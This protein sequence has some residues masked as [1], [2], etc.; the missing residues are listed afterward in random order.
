MQSGQI[1]QRFL[2]S[3]RRAATL[4]VPTSFAVPLDAVGGSYLGGLPKL[5]DQL[6]WPEVNEEGTSAGLI[7]AGQIDLQDMPKFEGREALPAAGCLYFFYKDNWEQ[8][9]GE[10]G[11]MPG[12]V[13]YSPQS[14]KSMPPRRPP[15][16]MVRLNDAVGSPPIFLA[17]EEYRNRGH[18][19]FDLAFA[20]FESYPD[21]IDERDLENASISKRDWL[22]LS[23]E[24]DVIDS[25][26][27]A[28]Q[29]SLAAALQD[30]IRTRERPLFVWPPPP[31][32]IFC[33]DVIRCYARGILAPRE[34]YYQAKPLSS[35]DVDLMS[36]AERWLASTAT[37]APLQALSIEIRQ[38][39]AVW[40]AEV[41]MSVS[42]PGFSQFWGTRFFTLHSSVLP[43]LVN[44]AFEQGQR[45]IAPGELVGA[46]EREPFLFGEGRDA[47]VWGFPL[48][49]MLGHGSSDHTAVQP[50]ER[51]DHV[52]LLKLDVAD[53]M[54]P[55]GGS[56]GAFHYWITPEALA[57]RDFS[58][59]E[60][61]C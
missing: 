37:M 56:E 48:H 43:H 53:A 3:V 17:P 21:D 24:V 38:E 44:V 7:F 31:E 18:F 13:L 32:W 16:R 58:S 33:A 25:A 51:R 12:R 60:L 55:R 52:L 28:N 42:A 41:T 45:E 26:V 47:K 50:L 54:V 1:Q 19:R 39:F 2:D 11:V 57:V 61:T 34:S 59:V 5:P 6:D 10:S 35:V 49:Q 46:L 14:P 30:R 27:R 29:K 4:L 8:E 20:A 15:A 22:Q 23:E 9:G 36:A 40:L